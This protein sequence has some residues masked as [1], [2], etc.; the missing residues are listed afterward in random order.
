MYTLSKVRDLYGEHLLHARM[1]DTPDN[2]HNFDA[3]SNEYAELDEMVRG[4][5]LSG[6]DQVI[7]QRDFEIRNGQMKK[8]SPTFVADNGTR[9]TITPDSVN[10]KRKKWP[11]PFMTYVRSTHNEERRLSLVRESS[12][13]SPLTV[14]MFC[15]AQALG[16]LVS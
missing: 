8:G 12:I 4:V 16:Y 1:I 14:F 11:S 10:F 9:V 2:L 3:K 6:V 15:Q 7:H 5:L 13:I